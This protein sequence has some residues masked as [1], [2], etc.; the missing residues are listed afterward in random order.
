MSV[1][2]SLHPGTLRYALAA[3]WTRLVVQPWPFA[4]FAFLALAGELESELLYDSWGPGREAGITFSVWGTRDAPKNDYGSLADP[5]EAT[6]LGARG[7]WGTPAVFLDDTAVA[8]LLLGLAG[9][10]WLALPGAR[11]VRRIGGP[12]LLALWGCGVAG[13]ALIAGE[14]LWRWKLITSG[15]APDPPLWWATLGIAGPMAATAGVGGT[16]VAGVV[17]AGVSPNR[18]APRRLLVAGAS[19]ATVGLAWGAWYLGSYALDLLFPNPFGEYYAWRVA[20]AANLLTAVAGPLLL[21]AVMR[22]AAIRH[23]VCAP[24][25]ALALLVGAILAHTVVDAASLLI[26]ESGGP[27]W[28]FSSAALVWEIRVLPLLLRVAIALAH[29]V[30]ALGCALALANLAPPEPER[31]AT[32]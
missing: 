16:L 6:L 21:A 12:S 29:A 10:L 2:P 14:R 30:L 25:V 1:M 3:A 13:T 15:I 20:V 11:R 23:W 9:L 27:R 8:G 28:S 7:H 22:G 17:L 5:L 24:A 19:A 32:R 18:L 4:V 26:P 31:G